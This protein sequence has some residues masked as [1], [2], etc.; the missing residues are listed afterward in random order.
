L[1]LE[2]HARFPYH[3]GKEDSPIKIIHDRNNPTMSIFTMCCGV[4]QSSNYKNW[5]STLPMATNI[6][7]LCGF[8]SIPTKSLNQKKCLSAISTLIK[9]HDETLVGRKKFYR[10]GEALREGGLKFLASR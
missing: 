2:V 8:S 3:F 7:P 4:S 9:S 1:I 5:F 6:L 10:A